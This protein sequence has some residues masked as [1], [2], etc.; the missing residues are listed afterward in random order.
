[1]RHHSHPYFGITA[2]LV[3]AVPFVVAL[4][5]GGCDSAPAPASEG[6]KATG[7]HE[8]RGE[9]QGTTYSIKYAAEVRVADSIFTD[10]LEMV[11]REVSLWRSDSRI[12]AIN[13]WSRTD[14]L[15]GFVD[16]DQIIGP[17]WALSEELHSLTKG[18][19]DPTVSP[20][21]ELW[22]FG[23]S[24]MGDVEADDVDSV[25]SFVGLMPDRFDLNEEEENGYYKAT[26]VRKGDARAALD[27]NAIAQGYTVDLL[28]E[29][30][31]E[32]GV[33]DA[34]V[35]LGGEVVCRGKN[36]VGGP[37]R[38]AVDQPTE[39]STAENRTFEVVVSIHDRAICTSGSYRKFHEVNGRKISHTIDPG[40]GWPAANGLLSATVMAPTGAYA[41]ALATAFMVLGTEQTKAFLSLHPELQLDAMLMYDDGHGGYGVWRSPGFDAVSEQL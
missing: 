40:T 22:G 36:P 33:Q 30:L 4:M 16:R 6:L 9:A 32:R 37:W 5:L 39:G 28:M 23:F 13:A 14:S 3:L 34:M 31:R 19:F 41:D 1:M 2:S 15:Y 8:H 17:L 25:M 24:E 21:V 7:W 27:F 35:E 38:I 10:L 18:A 20:L 11:D 29:A 26:W 12:N